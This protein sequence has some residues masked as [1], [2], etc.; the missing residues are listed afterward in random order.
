MVT[1]RALFVTM[2]VLA[3]GAQRWSKCGAAGRAE[4]TH[5]PLDSVPLRFFTTWETK[6]GAR[7]MADGGSGM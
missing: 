1:V 7:E 6:H 2:V 4:L 5:S 3:A